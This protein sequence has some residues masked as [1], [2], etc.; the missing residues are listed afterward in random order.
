MPVKGQGNDVH[1]RFQQVQPKRFTSKRVIISDQH[2]YRG[3]GHESSF[4]K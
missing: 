2:S 3:S 4:P 1:S